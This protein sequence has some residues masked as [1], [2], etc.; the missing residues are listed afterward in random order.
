MSQIRGSASTKFNVVSDTY[1][2]ADVPSDGT[3]GFVTVITPSGALTSVHGFFVVPVITGIAPTSG[4]VG[5][6]VAISG[7][8]FVGATAVKFGGVRPPASR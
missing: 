8:G 2:T 6:Q 7:S 4:P 3:S 1:M 5:S